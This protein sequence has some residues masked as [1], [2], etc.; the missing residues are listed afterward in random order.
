MKILEYQ[1]KLV[2]EL[3]VN[4]VD[5]HPALIPDG[6][7]LHSVE[8]VEGVNFHHVEILR[9]IGLGTHS[10]VYAVRDGNV[11]SGEKHVEFAVKVEKPIKQALG[12]LVREI[13]V[14]KSLSGC[15]A[16]P[17]YLGAF[18]VPIGGVDCL[19]A[20][21]EIFDES[22][23]SLRQPG[24]VVEGRDHRDQ[25][26]D[27]VSVRMF[28]ALFKIHDRGY[29]HRDIKPSNFMYKVSRRRGDPRIV[30]V[31]FGS[32]IAIGER[33][34]YPFRGTGAYSGLLMDPMESKP[35][36]DYWSVAFCILDLSIEGGLPWR[37]LSSR[38]DEGRGEIRKQ[39][40]DL[41]QRLKDGETLEDIKSRLTCLGRKL[42]V[43][44]FQCN[45]DISEFRSLVKSVSSEL[46]FDR[47]TVMDQLRPSNYRQAHLPKGLQRVAIPRIFL[48]G[49]YRSEMDAITS[50]CEIFQEPIDAGNGLL[51]LCGAVTTHADQASIPVI[52]GKRICIS[53][54]VGTCKELNC[55]LMHV[56]AKGIERS[57]IQ[58][59]FK[60][61]GLC[62]DGLVWK[63]RD[64]KCQRIHLAKEDL[65]RIFSTLATPFK[66]VRR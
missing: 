32:S 13:E 27:W 33:N 47:D 61:Q 49:K 18:T 14:L 30:L 35:L 31:D 11:H 58:R 55:P 62:M 51:S 6:T 28:E 15:S 17:R 24:G 46:I 60:K 48:H 63:C 44:L 66:R 54:L 23:S 43:S 7:L 64:E 5:R 50:R 37:S 9:R 42:V 8:L 34:D 53:D 52:D 1:A 4:P 20:G 41:L 3:S 26:L 40:F 10:E 57:A 56:P 29:L 59:P 39:K 21:L 65:K 36:D 16:T 38:T 25:L 2:S 22:L 45:S 19:A 12:C